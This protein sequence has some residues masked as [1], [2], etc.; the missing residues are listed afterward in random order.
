MNEPMTPKISDED[1]AELAKIIA[2]RTSILFA[3]GASRCRR[4]E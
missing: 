4:K 2:H 1:A 3:G